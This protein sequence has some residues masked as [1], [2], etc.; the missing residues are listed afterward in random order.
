MLQTI[1]SIDKSIMLFM[2]E[3][4]RGAIINPIMIFFST[5]GNS[6]AVWLILGAFLIFSKRNKKAGLYVILSVALCY[7]FNDLIIK[8][9]VARPRPF[10]EIEALTV[11]VSKPGSYSFPSGHACAGFAASYVLTK[12]YGKK[13]A[14]FYALAVA[15]SISRPFVG[16]HYPSDILVGAIVGTI[17]SI[18]LCRYVFP[19]FEDLIKRRKAQ[20]DA[21]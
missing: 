3:N 10:L 5:I 20:K 12:F 14:A 13:G 18:L 6:G 9:I 21:E 2:Q 7:V 8:P 16:V 11:L 15:I 4:L 1:F 17:G 19:Y